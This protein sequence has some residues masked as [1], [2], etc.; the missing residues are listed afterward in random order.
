M[1][2]RCIGPKAFRE[3]FWPSN[4]PGGY[5]SPTLSDRGDIC[6]FTGAREVAAILEKAGCDHVK[7][8]AQTEAAFS[9]DDTKDPFSRSYFSGWKILL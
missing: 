6:A 8:A 5:L 7:A 3:V 4:G 9:I 1:T 2:F